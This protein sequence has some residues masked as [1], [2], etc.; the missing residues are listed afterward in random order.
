MPIEQK[1]TDE[2]ILKALEECLKEPKIPASSV[3]N[4]LGASQEYIKNR[5]KKLMNDSESP[6]EG[7]LIGSSWCF[8]PKNITKPQH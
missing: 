8:R 1:Y 3:A 2:M 7:E 4:K 5:L 6:V